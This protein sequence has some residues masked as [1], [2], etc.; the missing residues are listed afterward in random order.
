MLRFTAERFVGMIVTMLLVSLMVFII[1]ELPPGDYADRYAFRKY[2]G[3]GV[4]VTEADIQAIRVEL[5]L[6]KPMLL[7]YFDWIGNIV[8]HGDFGQAFAFETSVTKVIGDKALL[9]TAILFGT[10]IITYLVSI[11]IGIYAAVKRASFADYGLTTFSYLGLALP[12][13]LLALI[14]L[15][16]A[17]RWFNADI[18]GLFSAEMKDAPWSLAKAGDLIA[19][20]WLPAIVLAWS[21]VAYQLQTVRAT[22]SDELNKLSVTAARARGVPETK[23]LIKY[24]ARLAINPVV[25]TI[26]FDVNR[27]FS[28]LPIVAVV[29]G[30]TELGEL[31]LRAYLD[32]DMYVAGAILLLLTFMIVFM[33]FISDILLAWLD[34]RIKLGG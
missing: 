25:S 1:M 2:S 7:R 6:D 26:G 10:L 9:T 27:I 4:S 18:G 21:A 12:N 14:L 13:F 22:M 30:L 34:P 31:L 19:H 29:L 32:L 5:G 16:F 11:P 33:N 24:P 28:E 15:Y 20:L 17:N 3:T 23:L 8:L